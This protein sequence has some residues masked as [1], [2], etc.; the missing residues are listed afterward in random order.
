[1]EKHVPIQC[2]W[3][4][5]LNLRK[6]VR[7][8]GRGGEACICVQF[9]S[10][11]R[12]NARG[13]VRKPTGHA[14]N[15]SDPPR[16]S[17]KMELD[18]IASSQCQ[19]TGVTRLRTRKTDG[20]TRRANPH[21][22]NAGAVLNTQYNLA[23]Q[24][25]KKTHLIEPNPPLLPPRPAHLVLT[26]SHVGRNRRADACCIILRGR[27]LLPDSR[28]QEA[29]RTAGGMPGGWREERHTHGRA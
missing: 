11:N 26:A 22:Y 29:L 25:I 24:I 6:S 23:T 18:A 20:E 28:P 15:G 8:S 2:A 13:Q 5:L 1:M 7:L 16:T 10:E 9:A 14:V 21:P 3:C 19:E 12:V 17:E 4:R 27:E